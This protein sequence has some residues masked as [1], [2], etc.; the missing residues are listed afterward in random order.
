MKRGRRR[1]PI[2][3]D[4][5]HYWRVFDGKTMK[6]HRWQAIHLAPDTSL[7]RWRNAKEW[8]LSPYEQDWRLP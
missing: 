4:S 2:M 3:N 1:K 8:G 6:G 5:R 7:S